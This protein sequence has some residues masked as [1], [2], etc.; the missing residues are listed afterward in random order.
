M[1]TQLPA[2]TDASPRNPVCQHG[3]ALSLDDKPHCFECEKMATSYGLP[4]TARMMD[5]P[6]ALAFTALLK[7]NEA[8]NGTPAPA[9]VYTR[10]STD[11]VGPDTP[12]V[13]MCPRCTL[14]RAVAAEERLG[15]AALDKVDFVAT[16]TAP[17][18]SDRIAAATAG[19]ADVGVRSRRGLDALMNDLRSQQTDDVKLSGGQ[20][21][22]ERV[23]VQLRS[24]V[25]EATQDRDAFAQENLEL[26]GKLGV[27]SDAIDALQES[28]QIANDTV[29]ELQK[30]LDAQTEA[31]AAQ[32]A[33]YTQMLRLY[34]DAIGAGNIAELVRERNGLKYTVEELRKDLVTVRTERDTLRAKM[35]AVTD[36]VT[37]FG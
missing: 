26:I 5:Y 16:R 11:T 33:N 22:L 9:S 7:A 2:S 18:L 13:C 25:S 27:A 8:T 29:V 6:N 3:V 17:T 36:C 32:K 12:D 10:P 34:N 24:E 14:R 28:E 15:N 35:Q 37:R 30:R 23:V 31:T 1:T 21:M 20:R 4:G 19:A